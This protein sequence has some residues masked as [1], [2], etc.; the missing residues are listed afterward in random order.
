MLDSPS[1]AALFLR[2]LKAIC[3]FILGW[4]LLEALFRPFMYGISWALFLGVLSGLVDMALAYR[5]SE[6]QRAVAPRPVLVL[7]VASFLI[8]AVWLVAPQYSTHSLDWLHTT[9]VCALMVPPA[10][11]V[12]ASTR[13]LRLRHGGE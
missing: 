1:T 9:V 12:V 4:L 10:Y 8:M 7:G 3:A 6:W 11:L 2:G 5:R 13:R